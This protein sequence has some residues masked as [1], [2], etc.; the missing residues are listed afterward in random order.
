MRDRLPVLAVVLLLGA[1]SDA[2]DSMPALGT[3]ERDRLELIAE[4]SQ[5][6]IE[7]LAREGD[8]VTAGQTLMRLDTDVL[9]AQTDAAQ[10]QVNEARN[11]LEE[12]IRGPRHEQILDA[13]ARLEAAQT[14]YASDARE[15]ERLRVLVEQH[16]TSQSAADRQRAARDGALAERNSAEAQLTLLLKGTRIEEL[17]QARDALKQAEAQ[18]QGAMISTGR[19]TVQAPRA[20]VIEAV[21]YKL[22]ERPPTGAPVVVMLADGDTYARVYVPA[23]LRTRVEAGSTA[24]VSIDGEEKPLTGRVRYIAAEAAF[25]PYYALTQKDRGRLSYLAEVTVTD[26]RSTHFPVGIPVEV[27]FPH[28]E[29]ASQ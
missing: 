10:A 26:A 4:S 23:T 14:Q 25:T 12:L 29:A 22:G 1:C 3:L 17:D 7:I 5:P 21:P 9:K 24:E 27:R 13:R 19:L 16:L 6:I 20:G 11:H 2:P 28:G 8:H 18:L 15:Y